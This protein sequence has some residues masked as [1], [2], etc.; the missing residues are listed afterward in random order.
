MDDNLV[1]TLGSSVVYEQGWC[2]P[3]GDGKV[4]EKT[5]S[6]MTSHTLGERRIRGETIPEGKGISIGFW[7]CTKDTIEGVSAF[8]IDSRTIKRGILIGIVVILCH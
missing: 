5:T 6:L 8:R 1:L 3:N 4:V 7:F 2:T